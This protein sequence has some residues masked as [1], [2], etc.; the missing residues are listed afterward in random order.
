MA[1][2]PSSDVSHL[3][4]FQDFD[5]L[6][7]TKFF[8]KVGEGLKKGL[9]VANLVNPG[10]AVIRLG[11]LAS[12]KLNMFQIAKNIRWAYLTD[13]Q[14]KE[15]GL[16]M[17][18]LG[19]LRNILKKIEDI[20]Y[21]AGG[22]V[23]NLKKEILTGRGNRD[24]AV[25]LSGLGETDDFN[26]VDNYDENTPLKELLSGVFDEESGQHE[27]GTNGLG[28][29]ATSAAIA[30]VTSILGTIA[31]LIKKLGSMKQGGGSGAGADNGGAQD[32]GA[33]TSNEND[34]SNNNSNNGASGRKSTN[35]LPA[36][37]SNSTNGA[38]DTTSTDD[39][40][41]NTQ[42]PQTF[43]E[44]AKAWVHEHPV[45][46]TVIGVATVGLISFGIVELHH[47]MKKKKQKQGQ[48]P[49]LSGVSRKKRRGKKHKGHG[50]KQH[51]KPIALL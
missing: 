3:P 7:K 2:N 34:M 19:H 24:K 45:K 28:V 21:G 44:K 41:N 15:K 16:D 26:G 39:A 31:A 32:D 43:S 29:I 6:G 40:G 42:A 46:A 18:K 48:Q 1:V 50:K 20:F 13:E 11:V 35:R 47:H 30:S 9:H 38:V 33:N 10:M 36:P 4:D 12:M 14:A 17:N 27:T 8:E 5:G 51:K 22:K 25:P 37:T 23:A 49:A